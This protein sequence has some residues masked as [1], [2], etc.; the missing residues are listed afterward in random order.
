MKKYLLSFVLTLI[1]CLLSANSF[2]NVAADSALAS[3]VSQYKNARLLFVMLPRKASMHITDEKNQIYTLTLKDVNP[4]V[5]YFADRPQ[6]FT[7][8]I[9]LENFIEQ[10]KTGDF[11]NAPPNAVMQAV[12]LNIA[13]QVKHAVDYVIEL[14]D[15]VYN[16]KTNELQFKIR[17][18]P[19]NNTPLPQLAHSSYV[20]VFI[21]DVC[22]SCIGG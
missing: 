18:L 14:N 7:G 16:K 12:H 21:D 8:E 17:A 6:R 1:A 4:S 2:A 19:G 20:A 10:W 9:K 22:F 3:K 15:P 5:I 11:R 13:D